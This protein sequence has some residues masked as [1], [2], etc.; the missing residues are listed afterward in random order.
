MREMRGLKEFAKERSLATGTGGGRK[1]G[2]APSSGSRS[3][4]GG[5]SMT[6]VVEI[7]TALHVKA[8]PG[9]NGVEYEVHFDRG[10]FPQGSPDGRLHRFRIESGGGIA[11]RGGAWNVR[12]LPDGEPLGPK[13]TTRAKLR[14][15]ILESMA[16]GTK[17]EEKSGYEVYARWHT[18]GTTASVQWFQRRK[19]RS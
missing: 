3:A 9:P 14:R 13:V 1:R 4:W 17:P 5:L 12:R 8:L 2:R 6:D 16:E 18:F 11:G 7:L 10:V 15:Q 19:R